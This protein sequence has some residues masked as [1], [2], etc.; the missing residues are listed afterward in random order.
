MGWQRRAL[1]RQM[2]SLQHAAT[3]DY[4][5]GGWAHG[6]VDACCSLTT[7]E[8]SELGRVC[9]REKS[10]RGSAN[11][12]AATLEASNPVGMRRRNGEMNGWEWK[13]EG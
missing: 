1:L 6:S 8:I 9:E 10:V 3:P 13:V 5:I 12:I 7:V 4:V 11:M 2:V